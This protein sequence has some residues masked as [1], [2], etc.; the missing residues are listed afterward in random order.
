[1]LNACCSCL[2]TFSS[3][4]LVPE[5]VHRLHDTADAIICSLSFISDQLHI[6][7]SRNC[8]IEN[9]FLCQFDLLKIIFLD[10]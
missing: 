8:Y 3:H 9:M 6:L 10:N 7:C 4:H 5:N 2:Y 1:M